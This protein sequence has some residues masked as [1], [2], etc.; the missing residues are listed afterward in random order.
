VLVGG[1]RRR[2]RDVRGR[3]LDERGP[4]EWWVA[5]ELL[6]LAVQL[7]PVEDRGDA[8]VRGRAVVAV[9]ATQH[10]EEEDNPC[11]G[12]EDLEDETRHGLVVPRRRWMQ[13]GG[14]GT[15]SEGTGGGRGVTGCDLTTLDGV[16]GGC[17]NMVFSRANGG[18][19]GY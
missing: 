9:D 4:A 1:V 8:V 6:H 12:A 5:L 17:Y 11:E 18:F 19:V 3:R 15:W 10:T 2:R 7:V 14:D 13:V 16:N